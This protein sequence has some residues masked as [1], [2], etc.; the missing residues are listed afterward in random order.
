[1]HREMFRAAALTIIFTV[2][3]NSQ[4]PALAAAPGCPEGIDCESYNS[5]SNCVTPTT[6]EEYNGCESL[7]LQ[8][9]ENPDCARVCNVDK[10]CVEAD[11]TGGNV[12]I[13]CEY[14]NM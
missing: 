1:M 9:V 12:E 2:A 10:S 3:H 8:L 11:C 4:P 6:C 7:L 14:T 13:W 5:Y